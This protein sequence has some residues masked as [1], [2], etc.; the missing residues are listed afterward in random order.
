[1]EL[2][3]SVMAGVKPRDLQLSVELDISGLEPDPF[4]GQ[5]EVGIQPSHRGQSGYAKRQGPTPSCRAYGPAP[6]LS[7]HHGPA[8]LS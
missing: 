8:Y 5:Q 7:I 3:I 1:M 6:I 2:D 4:V